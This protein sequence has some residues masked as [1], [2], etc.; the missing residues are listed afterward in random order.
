MQ[1]NFPKSWRAETKPHQFCPGCGHG[2]ALKILGQV[3]DELGIENKTVLGF[4]I[5]CSL[6][7]GKFFEVDSLQTH[8][9][10]TV[11]VMTGFKKANPDAICIAYMGDGGAYAIGGQHIVNS[12]MRN[13]KITCLVVNNTL[14]GMTGGQMAPTTMVGEK[15]DTTPFGRKVE[16]FGGPLKGPEMVN[17]ICDDNAYV[18]RSIVSSYQNLKTTIKRAI[19]YQMRGHGF[20]FAEILSGCPT[21]WKTNAKET[22]KMLEEE[23]A[24]KFPV[25]EFRN[26]ALINRD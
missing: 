18:A 15:T 8:H 16:E 14:Y 10:R 24:M 26:N 20:A 12:A 5:G 1:N 3:I 7:A 25:K 22:L 6:L 19:L 13:D 23:M 4:D 9:G 17:A 11:P 21:N 2:I